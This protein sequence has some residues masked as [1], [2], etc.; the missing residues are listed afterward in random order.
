[1]VRITHE[2]EAASQTFSPWRRWFFL[3]FVVFVSRC[4]PERAAPVSTSLPVLF[5]RRHSERSEESLFAFRRR[6]SRNIAPCRH[7][8]ASAPLFL[9]VFLFLFYVV[10]PKRAVF[11][12]SRDLSSCANSV[13]LVLEYRLNRL[14]DTPHLSPRTV[15]LSA[16]KNPSSP[17][18]VFVSRCHPVYNNVGQVKRH[19]CATLS[20]RVL[21]FAEGFLATSHH[22]SIAS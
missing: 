11:S 14:P 16:A 4:H 20:G 13:I 21:P 8:V 22:A 6:P 2:V 17:L 3:V 7:C 19:V 1:V 15:I 9:L 12:E 10:I 18:L 5:L